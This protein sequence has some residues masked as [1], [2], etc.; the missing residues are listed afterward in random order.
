[1]H[2]INRSGCF[3]NENFL[4]LHVPAIP[5]KTCFDI[6]PFCQASRFREIYSTEFG[7]SGSLTVVS[8]VRKKGMVVVM[9]NINGG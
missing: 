6:M 2:K 3:L 1:M 9:I 4:S 5:Q 8:Y 7:F